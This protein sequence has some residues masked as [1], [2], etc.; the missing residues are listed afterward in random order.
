MRATL[1]F[2][3]LI[4]LCVACGAT[5][6]SGSV[7]K[8]AKTDTRKKANNL[9]RILR[10]DPKAADRLSSERVWLNRDVPYKIDSTAINESWKEIEK[11]DG[12]C[13]I[14]M[15]KAARDRILRP[16]RSRSATNVSKNAD[17]IMTAR[18]VEGD[19]PDISP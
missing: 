9:R 16:S 5:I 4:V 2:I 17:T 19:M 6:T 8:M 11:R 18:W 15:I 3:S 12:G 1:V 13:T 14:R 10:P 7:P